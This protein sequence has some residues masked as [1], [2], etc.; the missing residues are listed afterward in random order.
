LRVGLFTSPHLVAFGERI[1][2]NRV[3]LPEP[4]VVALVEKVR[5]WLKTFGPDEHPTFFEAVTVMALCHFEQE[6]CDLVI[7][8]T[9]LGGRLDATNIVTPLASVIT[10]IQFDHQ[11]WLG[12]TLAAIASEKAGI[13]KP[14]VSVITAAD[15]PEAWEVIVEVARRQNAPLTRVTWAETTQPPLDAIRLPLAGRHQRLNAALATTTARVLGPVIPVPPAALRQG[16]ESL[17]WPGRLQVVH[18]PGGQTVLLDGAHNVAGTRT[19]VE[20]LRDTYGS[21]RPTLVLGILQ[22]KDWEEMCALLAPAARRILLVR[23]PSERT[24]DPHGLREACHRANPG[25]EV[26]EPECLSRALEAAAGDPFVV[27]TGSLYLVGEALEMF[28]APARPGGERGLNEWNP[29]GDAGADARS[30]G[31]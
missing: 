3:P 9:G 31:N 26:L 7:W 16:L 25:V 23:V 6:Q 22:D 20:A 11:K 5:P 29:S 10:N 4:E 12:S 14:G 18:R 15:E 17:E 13:I 8:E 19:L 2:V 27:I 21:L 1:Q 24:M 28:R 30:V